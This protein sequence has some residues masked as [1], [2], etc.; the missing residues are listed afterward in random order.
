LQSLRHEIA[1]VT[2]LILALLL[3]YSNSLHVPFLLDDGVTI[4]RNPSI[5]HLLP[6]GPVLDP[7][8]AALSAGRPLL[9]LSYAINFCIGGRNV[10]IYHW[11]NLLIHFASALLLFRIV[12]LLATTYHSENE[13]SFWLALAIALIWE[14]HPLQTESV[15]YISQRAESLMGFMYLSS[16]YCFIRGTQKTS[17]RCWMGASVAACAAGMATKEVMVTAPVLILLSDIIVLRNTLSSIYQRRLGYYSALFGTWLLLAFLMLHTNGS[18]RSIGYRGA[19]SWVSYGLTECEVVVRYLGLALCP[20]PLVF[21]YG[22]SIGFAMFIG[23]EVLCG[24]FLLIALIGCIRACCHRNIAA[25]LGLSFFILLAPTSSIIPIQLQPMA[26]SRM[27]LPLAPIIAIA[28]FLIVK[29]CGKLSPTL[30]SVIILVFI[31]V[32]VDRNRTYSSAI[33]IWTDTVAKADGNARA[34]NE[35]ANSLAASNAGWDP[36][37]AQYKEALR[38]DP[39]YAVAQNNIALLYSQK[40]G[41][42]DEALSHYLTA[43]QLVPD[44]FDA[45]Y[46]LANLLSERVSTQQVAIEQ[47]YEAITLNPLSVEAHCNL[48]TLLSDIPGKEGEA[49]K[50]FEAAIRLDPRSFAVH[51]N[52]GYLLDRLPGKRPQAI[53]QFRAAIS[54]NPNF[55]PAR[56]AI[57]NDLRSVSQ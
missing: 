47:Y 52:Y 6:I 7:P 5:E 45:H 4:L 55:E 43:I 14:V 15:T 53:A 32:T 41:Y 28:V 39:Y 54:L 57:A 44:Y 25:F 50:E 13:T 29:H 19:Y 18:T 48:A 9:N 3:S 23:T 10:T 11:S 35:L 26:E 20:Y 16:F 12:S 42:R 46:N 31:T 51:Y 37:L 2:A 8:G 38:I 1:A 21:D 36:T 33:A 24:A 22:P 56:A 27:Y 30:L 17:S 40:P 34:H 49:A